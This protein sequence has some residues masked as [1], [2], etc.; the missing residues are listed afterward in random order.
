MSD[1]T[2]A[3]FY[4]IIFKQLPQGW[5][6]GGKLIE[7][8][9]RKDNE[10][11]IYKIKCRLRFSKQKRISCENSVSGIPGPGPKILALSW[12]HLYQTLDQL[13][14]SHGQCHYPQSSA[15]PENVFKTLLTGEHE[16]ALRKL[17]TFFIGIWTQGPFEP[18]LHFEFMPLF[19][20]IKYIVI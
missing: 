6:F 4:I 3:P 10:I 13:F 20:Y 2:F 8:D 18:W 9:G 1:E 17:I 16:E 11:Q 19:R 15:Q 14:H 12:L 5:G 7:K